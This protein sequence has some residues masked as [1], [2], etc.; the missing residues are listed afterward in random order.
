[1]RS[2]PFAVLIRRPNARLICSISQAIRKLKKM[3]TPRRINKKYPKQL[4][5]SCLIAWFCV[6]TSFAQSQETPTGQQTPQSPPPTTDSTETPAQLAEKQSSFTYGA[7]IDFNSRYVW[8]GLLLDD[9]R[10][11]EPSAWISAFGFTL[12]AYSYVALT[13]A[14]GGAGL[15]ATGLTLTYDRDWKKFKIEAALDGYMGRQ[16][17]DIEAQNTMEG[18]L[19]L[20][21]PAGPLRIFTAHAF[22]VLAYR[23]AYFGEAGLEYGRPVTKSAEFT[24]SVRS[25]W[26]SAKF[27]DVYIGVN[28]SAFNLVGVEGELTYYLGRRLYFRPHIEFSSITDPSLREQLAPANIVN[29]GLAFGFTK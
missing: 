3:N 15:K 25:G 10:A 26:A 13:S 9:G 4:L 24:T 29:F 7:E 21:Y 20:S 23:G 5:M 14:S 18:S 8:R 27:N 1:M 17:S 6:A 12:N 11:G 22:D 2:L 28:K 19:K 16:S